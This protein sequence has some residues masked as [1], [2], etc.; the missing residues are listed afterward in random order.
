[1]DERLAREQPH[2]FRRRRR[3]RRDA[4]A[5][6]DANRFGGHVQSF[7]GPA[8][9]PHLLSVP[10]LSH[11]RC[12]LAVTAPHKLSA[13][14]FG[15]LR[16]RAGHGFAHERRHPSA[17]A[18]LS[19]GGLARNIAINHRLR[20]WPRPTN[21]AHHPRMELHPFHEAHI[22]CV[23]GTPRFDR[24]ISDRR[25]RGSGPPSLTFSWAARPPGCRRCNTRPLLSARLLFVHW[26]HAGDASRAFANSFR[27]FFQRSPLHTAPVCLCLR[28]VPPACC[29]SESTTAP[30]GRLM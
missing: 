1:M 8:S 2:P 14:F 12:S 13:R 24:F 29:R 15:P 21:L 6:A 20:I 18:H 19:Q 7:G 27:R 10:T 16:S 26:G 17:S 23:T 28:R 22:L 11:R 5:D 4:D 30:F 3:R 9:A 25:Q